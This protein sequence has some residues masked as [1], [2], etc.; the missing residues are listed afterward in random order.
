MESSKEEKRIAVVALHKAGKSN[1]FICKL[2]KNLGINRMF[3]W[4][5]IKRYM[6]TLSVKDKPRP[7]RPRSVRTKNAVRAVAARIRRNPL[8]KQKIMSREMDISRRTMSRL[9]K[10]DLGMGAY[11][12]VT[13]QRLN[14]ALKKIRLERAKALLR[15]YGDGRYRKIMF[16]DEKIFTIEEKYNRQNDKVYARSSQEAKDKIGR[17]E[18]GH[19]PSSIMVWWE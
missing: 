11:R 1:S 5:T 13:G 16:S 19:H 6:D 17:V 15:R 3:V 2:L 7:G 14:N 8:R 4:R 12:R 9:I 18:R 10:N